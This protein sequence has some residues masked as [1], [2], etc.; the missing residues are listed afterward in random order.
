L[1]RNLHIPFLAVIDPLSGLPSAEH[2]GSV[3]KLDGATDRGHGGR[4]EA[5]LW[6]KWI[7]DLNARIINLPFIF[8]AVNHMKVTQESHGPR[9]VE[10]KY[11]P[12][13]IAQNFASTISLRCSAPSKQQISPAVQGDTYQDIW[14]ECFKNSRGPTGNRTWFRKYARRNKDGSTTFWWDWGR[15]TAEFLADLNPRHE[16]RDICHVTK[17]TENTFCCK[18]LGAK[19]ESPSVIGDA[20]YA[21]KK[22]LESLMAAFC[23]KRVKEYQPLS[24]E[25][26]TKLTEEAVVVRDKRVAELE[27]ENE[28]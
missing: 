27:K 23:W 26:Y 15:N 7:K 14:V 6:T 19:D 10:K 8:V 18:Q 11:N 16:V 24:T 22:L 9:Q 21:D 17:L 1:D 4:D 20:I 25:E 13:G 28:Q 3:E 12:G 2:K 5:L